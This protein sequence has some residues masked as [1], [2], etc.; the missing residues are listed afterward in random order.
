MTILVTGGSGFLGRYL[1]RGLLDKYQDIEIRTISRSGNAIQKLLV[2]CNSERLIP[3]IGDIKDLGSVKYALRDIDTVIHLAALKYIDLCEMYPVEAVATNINGTKNMLDSFNGDTFIS[4]STDKVVEAA[5]CYGATKLMA[6]KLVLDQAK[7]Q[8]NKKY[9][10][11]RCGN[12]F[13]STGSVID[14]WK[15]QIKQNNTISVTNLD[16]TRFF[17]NVEALVDFIIGIVESGENGNIYIP[18]QKALMLA[19]LARATIDLYG[20]RTT[21][22]DSVGIRS[23][24]KLHETLFTSREKVVSSL[25][26]NLSSDAPK[27]TIKEIKEWL[28]NL[29][30]N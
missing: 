19:D 3:V 20:N 13:G 9:M 2:E 30:N 17:I 6:E 18:Y 27:L 29:E 8:N 4:M 16:M 7:R 11:V 23:G 12:F 15:Q 26:S 22:L 5:G 1:I 14:K 21:R 24:E 25:T 28:R 10:I